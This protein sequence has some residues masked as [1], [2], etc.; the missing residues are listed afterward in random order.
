MK[1]SMQP[2]G[3]RCMSFRAEQS[4]AR[5]LRHLLLKGYNEVL[6]VA[7]AAQSAARINAGKNG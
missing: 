4:A 5:L 1:W 6:P 2:D 7:G 3:R